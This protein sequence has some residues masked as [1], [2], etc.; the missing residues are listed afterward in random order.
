M[1]LNLLQILILPFTSCLASMISI[2]CKVGVIWILPDSDFSYCFL[3]LS[4][5]WYWTTF[6]SPAFPAGSYRCV[7]AYHVS[8]ASFRYLTSSYQTLD[9][10]CVRATS[11]RH[12]S[13]IT[14]WLIIIS[15]VSVVYLLLYQLHY[16]QCSTDSSVLKWKVKHTVRHR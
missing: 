15:D 14:G 2:I 13:G 8:F 1:E 16:A 3:H 12:L 7:F 6:S 5:S 11:S 10:V 4:F 9:T